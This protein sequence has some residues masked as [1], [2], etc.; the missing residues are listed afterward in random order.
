MLFRSGNIHGNSAIF[1]TLTLG[2]AG[3]IFG[4]LRMYDGA[5]GGTADYIVPNA[6]SGGDSIKMPGIG[7]LATMATTNGHQNFTD[8]GTIVSDGV[9]ATYLKSLGGLVEA[10]DSTSTDGSLRIF[11][12]SNGYYVD[13][14]APNTASSNKT[15]TLPNVSGTVATVSNS[16]SLQS[17]TIFQVLYNSPQVAGAVLDD[18]S[19]AFTEWTTDVASLKPIVRLKYV[20]RAGVKYIKARFYAKTSGDGWE[21]NVVCGSLTGTSASGVNASYGSSSTATLDVSG[22]TANTLYNLTFN[23][24]MTSAPT[25]YFKELII[26]SES[27]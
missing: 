19:A 23:I 20:H 16:D 14:T 5:A 13:V 12:S 7:L 10:G 22:L 24:R 11:N 4:A 27:N 26:T 3:T 9:T 25:A 2:T 1:D 17:A 18:T 8:V 15:L 6:T 21:A